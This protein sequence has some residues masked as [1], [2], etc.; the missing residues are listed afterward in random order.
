MA[1]ENF[2]LPIMWWLNPFLVAI[3]NRANLGVIKKI[4]A[5]VLTN[6][7]DMLK[8]TLMGHLTQDGSVTSVWQP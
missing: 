1:I 6:M 8:Q 4:C 7:I 5:P 3:N 2:Q